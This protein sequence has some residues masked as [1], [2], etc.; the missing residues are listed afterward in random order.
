MIK[1]ESVQSFDP[2]I[3]DNCLVLILGSVPSVKSKEYGFYYMHPQNRFWKVLGSIFCDNNMALLSMSAQEKT[4]FLL[5]HHIALYDSVGLCDIMGSSDNHITNVQSA[6]ISGLIANRNI[7][8]IFCNGKTAQKYLLKN[9]KGDTSIITTLPS[10][11]PANAKW[12]LE[13]LVDEW[14]IIKDY[15][16]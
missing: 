8:Q 6:D 12:L 11:S 15:L 4:Q 5:Q 9:F 10:T 13:K 7:K 16:E 14:K 1:R 2:I 3:D